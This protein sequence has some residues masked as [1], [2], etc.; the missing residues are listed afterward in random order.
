MTNKLT[1]VT[2]PDDI[3]EDGLR[4]LLVG[5]DHQNSERVSTALTRL[6]SVPTTVIYVWNKGED[7]AWLFD[8]KQKSDIIIFD[9]DNTGPEL[10]GT[11]PHNQIVIILVYCENLN[12][13]IIV[14]YLM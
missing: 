12:L 8:K 9:A 7:R 10:M 14:R 13:L 2:A 5:L 4:I 1:L 6:E 3:L 11:W